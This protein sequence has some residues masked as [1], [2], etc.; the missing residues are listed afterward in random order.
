L[1]NH[2]GVFASMLSR[3]G[4]SRATKQSPDYPWKK[5]IASLPE[6][7]LSAAKGSLAM[8]FLDFLIIRLTI[9]YARA[10]YYV[11]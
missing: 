10:G 3:S 11:Q 6:L 7:A 5:E 1:K 9:H 2:Q 4:G 8:T